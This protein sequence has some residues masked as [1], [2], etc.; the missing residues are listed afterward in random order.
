M[1]C[2]IYIYMRVW[3][4]ICSECVNV[5]L[6]SS[7][8]TIAY[9]LFYKCTKSLLHKFYVNTFSITC[10]KCII[11]YSFFQSACSVQGAPGTTSLVTP[12]IVIPVRNIQ[13]SPSM[14]LTVTDN[15]LLN[16]SCL[17]AQCCFPF[18]TCLDCFLFIRRVAIAS[19]E[20]NTRWKHYLLIEMECF[21]HCKTI[22]M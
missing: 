2:C 18:R 21:K 17:F 19:K 1:I 12:D 9:H 13:C 15:T 14:S 3:R 6:D 16:N 20:M 10:I 22:T 7:S 11:F 8:C 5:Q 4:I